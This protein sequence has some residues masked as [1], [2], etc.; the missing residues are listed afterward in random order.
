ML[1]SVVIYRRN[2]NYSSLRF[3]LAP[4]PLM[5]FIQALFNAE[6]AVW[7]GQTLLTKTHM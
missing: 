2:V 5:A 6:Y 3:E 4:Q 7:E 1:R